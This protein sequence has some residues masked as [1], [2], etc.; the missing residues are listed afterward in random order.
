MDE[1]TM[2]D[3]V[4]A[5]ALGYHIPGEYVPGTNPLQVMTGHE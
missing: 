3:W 4:Y 1:L 2:L 5:L